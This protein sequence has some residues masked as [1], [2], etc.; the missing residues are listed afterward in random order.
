L[1]LKIIRNDITKVSADAI[2]NSANPKPKYGTGTDYAIYNAAG[3]D[4]LLAERKKI[5]NIHVGDIAVTPAFNLKA[6]YI[7][8]TVGPIWFGGKKA[9]LDI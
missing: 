4:E 8:H 2:V 7:I 5:G 9:S 3:L 6:K 1:P